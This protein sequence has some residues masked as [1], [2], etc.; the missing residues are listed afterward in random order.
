MYPVL[1]HI[2][3]FPIQAYGFFLALAHLLGILALLGLAWRE[4]YPLETFVDLVF[5]VLIFG[6]LG[7][8]A[9][10]V[11]THW[12]EF[13]DA[14]ASMTSLD[15]GG[16]A[17]FSGFLF[18]FFPF[19]IFLRWKK[20]PVLE[21]SDLVAP[22]L[23]L[24]LAVIRLGCFGAGCCYGKPTNLPL[25]LHF[26][27][28][29]RVPADLL[30]LALHPSQLYEFGATASL[31]LALFFLQRKRLF[32]PGVLATVCIA[33]YALYRFGA[34]FLRGDLERGIFP[35]LPWMS[36]TQFAA[37]LGLLSAPLVLWICHCQNPAKEKEQ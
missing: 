32:R 2:H 28:G 10:Y 12:P 11:A 22:V 14:P 1:F 17:F 21:I 35:W 30:P 13:R 37:S 31:A 6:L 16:L 33:S 18:A 25:G 23:P 20:L 19:L 7:A 26:H 4:G 5:V 27:A 34:D 9:G 15:K 3:G 8:R 24:T 29:S 36:L